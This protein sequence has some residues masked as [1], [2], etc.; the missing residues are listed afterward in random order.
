[1]LQDV[2]IITF[3][4]CFTASAM[5][6]PQF[7]RGARGSFQGH[8][9]LP[10]EAP[11][12]EGRVRPEGCERRFPIV[13][14]AL[15]RPWNRLRIGRR[16]LTRGEQ[17]S[18]RTGPPP[19]SSSWIM[20]Q[21]FTDRA[22]SNHLPLFWHAKPRP[23]QSPKPDACTTGRRSPKE[24]LRPRKHSRRQCSATRSFPESPSVRA[25]A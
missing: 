21:S 16:Q 4:F 10:E 25:W 5:V 12:I 22:P 1:M 3:T 8:R 18:F 20:P 6:S 11:G 24:A 23:F 15:R 14:A 13:R 7:R 9:E 19:V 2:L 17:V